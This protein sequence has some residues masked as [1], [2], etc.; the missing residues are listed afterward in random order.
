MNKIK[1]R[2]SLPIASLL[3]FCIIYIFISFADKQPVSGEL[4]APMAEVLYVILGAPF[5]LLGMFLVTIMNKKM[6]KGTK[7]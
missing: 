2:Y 5:S 1:L 6:L 3:P 4:G 7:P